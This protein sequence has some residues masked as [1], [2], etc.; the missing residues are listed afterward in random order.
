[1]KHK[2]ITVEEASQ[3]KLKT[4]C[5]ELLQSILNSGVLRGKIL[6][7]PEIFEEAIRDLTSRDIRIDQRERANI[8]VQKEL[9]QG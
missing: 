7:D 6:D 8:E 1:M 9:V 5:M 2:I 4:D 3:R